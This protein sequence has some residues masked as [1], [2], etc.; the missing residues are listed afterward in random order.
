[1]CHYCHRSP[2]PAVLGTAAVTHQHPRVPQRGQGRNPSSPRLGRWAAARP[3]AGWVPGGCTEH[4]RPKGHRSPPATLR[5]Q[6]VGPCGA[7]AITIGPTRGCA[8]G[9]ERFGLLHGETRLRL[10]AGAPLGSRCSRAAP[11]CVPVWAVGAAAPGGPTSGGV[12]GQAAPTLCKGDPRAPCKGDS[13]DPC[14]G[15]PGARGRPPAAAPRG[16]PTPPG[17][18]SA[19]AGDVVPPRG[20]AAG[21]APGAGLAPFPPPGPPERCHCHL[22]SGCVGM[23]RAQQ[24][25]GNR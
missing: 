22:R 25:Q 9:E 20:P 24:P 23:L 6:P 19:V 15:D 3:R 12:H 13:H 17:S 8:P 1:M 11:R 5:L 16:E 7:G 18:R 10:C 2:G 14:K 4:P 21:A